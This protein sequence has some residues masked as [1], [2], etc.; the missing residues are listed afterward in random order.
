MRRELREVMFG[1]LLP[2]QIEHLLAS[3]VVGRI[4]CHARG[5]TYVVPTTY[6]YIDGV[7]VCHTGTG[8][9]VR[10]MRENPNVCFEVEDLRDLP[11]WS[12]V[13]AFG[14]YEELEGEVAHRALRHLVARLGE[15]PPDLT[16]MPF[17]GAGTREVDTGA[18]PSGAWRPDVVFRII[19]AE[20]SGRHQP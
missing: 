14:R 11:R 17:Q 6:G 19:L 16:S 20:K 2:D 1:T 5:Q 4:G 13:I 10:M 18:W 15:S 7:I 3:Q 8:L 12:S 9:K